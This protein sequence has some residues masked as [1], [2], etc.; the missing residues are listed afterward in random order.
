MTET[1]TS[2]AVTS[3]VIEL[4]SGE[5][6]RKYK[7]IA[8]LGEGGMARVHL[9]VVR[10]IAGIRKLVVL[11]SV[12][13]EL[14]SDRRVCEMFLAEARLAATFNHPNIVQTFEVIVS[15]NRPLLVM[16]YMDGQPISRILRQPNL[17]PSL[18]LFVLGEVL[19]GL[20][21]A[22]NVKD[23]DGTELNLVHR[24]IS[25]QN[26][27]V[28]YD[29]HV[30]LL[31]FGIA[32]I[33]GSSGNT[34]TGEIKGK[35]RYMAPEQMLGSAKLDR[36]AD[37]FSVGVMLWEAVTR[38]RLWAG[39]NDVQVIQAVVSGGGVP[40]PSTV[41]PDVP[42]CLDAICRRALAHECDDRYESAAAM[43]ADLQ[44]AIEELRMRT[45]HRQVGR[46]VTESFV[47]LRTSIKSVIETQLS[48]EKAAPVSLIV[49]DEIDVVVTEEE[50]FSGDLWGLPSAVSANN[51][52][53]V[54]RRR[55]RLGLLAGGGAVAVMGVISALWLGNAH[56]RSAEA[57][58]TV[59]AA[60]P[61]TS[62]A[63]PPAPVASVDEKDRAY[64]HVSF[65]ANPV[66]ARLF[67]DDEL[68]PS[69]PFLGT[70]PR[71]AQ[72]HVLRVEAP[73]YRS[74]TIAVDLSGPTESKLDLVPLAT[75][76]P[77]TA[78]RPSIG[79]TAPSSVASTATPAPSARSC[80]PPF[81]FDE[82]G[83]KSFKP[84]CLK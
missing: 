4:D 40:A 11:K 70:R 6:S 68:L 21:Y 58:L 49:S 56:G 62:A 54:G 35:V 1:G 64:V 67:L 45:D 53:N 77:K 13:P 36:R 10:G 8:K 20:D 78:A 81:I 76:L 25:P 22:H 57:P 7:V 52:T 65:E 33:L 61:P 37:I 27:L 15:K 42:P 74:E 43:Q 83:I 16:E 29:G 5:F 47:D 55:R 66:R 34:E 38:Q 80:N 60:P 41:D 79:R 23:L 18:P 39:L 50:A 12:R 2:E 82:N 72:Q 17:P 19:N 48:N 14:V 75:V 24:D 44:A 73:G 31:D 30:K 63:I 9:A 28:T 3:D 26:V 51:L 84:E 71:D 32:K 59:A 46:F 69:N